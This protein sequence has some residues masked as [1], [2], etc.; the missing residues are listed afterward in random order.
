LYSGWN[1]ELDIPTAV[2]GLPVDPY[3]SCLV[4]V[5]MLDSTPNVRMLP[6]VVPLLVAHDL[7]HHVVDDDVAI[8][9][10]TLA[11]L[12]DEHG[13]F[14]GFDEIWFCSR[15]PVM[16]KPKHLRITSDRPL[17]SEPSAALVEWMTASSCSIGLGDGDG[18]NFVTRDRALAAKWR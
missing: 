18:L 12:I 8:E 16:G 9:F 11:T 1:A 14:S 5:S 6:S 10:A 2:A 7:W 13:M 3:A 15:A 4:L 17:E